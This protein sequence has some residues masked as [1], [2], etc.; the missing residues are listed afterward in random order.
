MAQRDTAVALSFLKKG[1]GNKYG[2]RSLITQ[3]GSFLPGLGISTMHIHHAAQEH[4]GI[5]LTSEV[6]KL[7]F[8][9]SR[10]FFSTQLF[11]TEKVH[12][13]GKPLFQA[14]TKSWMRE[15]FQTEKVTQTISQQSR[16]GDLEKSQFKDHLRTDLANLHMQSGYKPGDTTEPWGEGPVPLGA[17]DAVCTLIHH[18]GG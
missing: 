1:P 15:V 2:H 11:S 13:N 14:A 8:Q 3:T 12:D 16:L 10:I 17:V 18:Q 9:R 6:I 7:T 4:P 5:A